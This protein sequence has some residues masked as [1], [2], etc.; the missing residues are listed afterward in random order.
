MLLSSLAMSA[1][2]PSDE[3]QR[4]EAATTLGDKS[5]A[6]GKELNCMLYR[7]HL[8][9]H[10]LSTLFRILKEIYEQP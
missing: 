2:N 10:I 4:S 8:A 7:Q 1:Q 6:G 9:R 5:N 3:V